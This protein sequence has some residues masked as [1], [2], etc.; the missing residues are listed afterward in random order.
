[1]PK[2]LTVLAALLI[3]LA[4]N[5]Q[6]LALEELREIVLRQEARIAEL[7]RQQRE[8]ESALDATADFVESIDVVDGSTETT[9]GGYGELHYNSLDADDA[10]ND[11]DEIDFHRF[12]LFVGHR[13]GDRVRFFSELELEHALSGD[14]KPGEVELEQA[15]V[16]I[17]LGDKLS[18]R[19]GLF[20]LP[21]GFLNETHEPAT[22]YGVERNDVESIIVPTTWWEGGGGFSGNTASGF[23]WDIAMHSGLAM[24]TMGANAFRVRSGRQKVADALN[25]NW[26]YTARVRYSGRPGLELAASYQYQT[27]PSQ[28]PADGLD[29]GRLFVT[30][31]NWRRVAFALKAL[32]GS[33]RFDGAAVEAAGAG[34]Q[35]GWFVEPSYRINDRWGVYARYA[36][37]EGARPIDRFEQWESGLNF[38]LNPGV[39][40]KF[41]YRQR[42]LDS[43]A[44]TGEDFD[45]FDI[46]F[47]Y[48]F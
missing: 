13:F 14:D 27:D 2:S 33:W 7:E 15:Y 6:E 36:D 10:A 35:D 4:A 34:R 47:G 38:W 48:E 12:V 44:L 31:L 26:A 22:F 17:L 23:G 9:I 43:T 46:G 41:D 5:G 42:D 19:T 39:V 8:T 11:V 24:P 40:L 45:G 20:L 21:I 30:N 28:T 16:D 18:A 29:A 25:S 1:M 3:A 37:V 32:Y